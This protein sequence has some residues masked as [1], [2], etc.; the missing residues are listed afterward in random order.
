[1]YL[2]MN[3]EIFIKMILQVDNFLDF[4]KTSLYILRDGN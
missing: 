2:E 3:T 4:N 1:M